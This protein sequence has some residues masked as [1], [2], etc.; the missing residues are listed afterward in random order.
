LDSPSRRSEGRK[1]KGRANQEKQ[2]RIKSRLW[3]QLYDEPARKKGKK[4]KKRLSYTLTIFDP[5]NG[6][7][8]DSMLVGGKNISF[9]IL[10][11]LKKWKGKK[12]GGKCR[13]FRPTT[14]RKKRPV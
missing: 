4:G 14:V 10:V 3:L 6:A 8:G 13:R 7:K 5:K 9:L 1:K 11:A 2:K 12:K